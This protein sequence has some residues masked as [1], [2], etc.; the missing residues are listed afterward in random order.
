[1]GERGQQESEPRDPHGGGEVS[2]TDYSDALA[3]GLAV[4]AAF[5]A[6]HQLLTQADLAR[7]LGLSRA[8]VRRTVLTLQHLGYLEAE[9]RSYALSPHILR[10][11]ESYLTSNVISTVL[12]PACDKLSEHLD[13]S[14]SV[15]VLDGEDA[16]MIARA[17]PNRMIAT[18]SGVGF[19]VPAHRSALGSV[20][21]A[22]LNNAPAATERAEKH[23]IDRRSMTK[24]RD[25][26]FSYV[27]HEV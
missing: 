17:V 20:L 21:R 12:Q 24:V 11:A 2:A 23:P 5:D 6:D 16:V 14:C 3:R 10:V 26:G 27:A 15:A 19:R 4:L 8:T 22:N 25:D 9:G 18:G 1:M 13:A 7:Q